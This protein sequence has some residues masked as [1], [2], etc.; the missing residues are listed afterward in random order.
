MYFINTEHHAN[1]L[2]QSNMPWVIIYTGT[3][4]LWTNSIEKATVEQ[5]TTALTILQSR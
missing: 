2:G 4:T 1:E 5:R 3:V